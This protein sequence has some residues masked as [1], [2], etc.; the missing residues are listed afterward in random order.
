MRHVFNWS[1][2]ERIIDRTP[3]KRG[4]VTLVKLDTHAEQE[5]VRRLQP[6]ERERST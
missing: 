5:R 2:E 1:I 6:G 3:F 4:D